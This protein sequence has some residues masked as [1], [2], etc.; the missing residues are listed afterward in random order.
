MRENKRK[1]REKRKK[2]KNSEKN[3][4]KSEPNFSY[5]EKINIWVENINRRKTPMPTPSLKRGILYAVH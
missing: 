3:G 5:G 4:E 1:T 2:K